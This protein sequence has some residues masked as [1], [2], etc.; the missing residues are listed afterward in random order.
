[1]QTLGTQSKKNSNLN[2]FLLAVGQTAQFY[3]GNTHAQNPSLV[4]F[5]TVD[6]LKAAAE[7]FKQENAFF[8]FYYWEL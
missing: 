4:T 8:F 7:T 3:Q 5:K 6:K 1:M 2:D